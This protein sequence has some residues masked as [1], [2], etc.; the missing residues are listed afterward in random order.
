LGIPTCDKRNDF[1]VLCELQKRTDHELV[2]HGRPDW[3][4]IAM[5]LVRMR[6]YTSAWVIDEFGDTYRHYRKKTPAFIP[7]C[8]T[9]PGQGDPS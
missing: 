7:R 5:Q 4:V 9:I 8:N 6:F 1:T 3:Q 2:V